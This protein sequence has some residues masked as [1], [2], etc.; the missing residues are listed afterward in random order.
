MNKAHE[1]RMIQKAQTE[2]FIVSL[3]LFPRAIN[4]SLRASCRLV[5]RLLYVH[6]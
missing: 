5:V 4:I 2:H 6:Y 1:I 3:K